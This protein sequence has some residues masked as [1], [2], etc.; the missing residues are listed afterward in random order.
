MAYAYLVVAIA[1]EVVGTTLLKVTDGFTRLWPSLACLASYAVAVVLLSQAVR[2]MSVGVAYALWSGIGT[3]GI[4]AIAT[5][6]LHERL[7]AVKVLGLVL[8]VAGVVVL[9][10]RGAH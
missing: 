2:S 10:L 6:F 3:A 8:V 4:V 1:A 9:N 7:D 5:V